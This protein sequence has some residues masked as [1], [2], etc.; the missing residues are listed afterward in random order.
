MPHLQRAI[1]HARLHAGG[2]F[3]QSQQIC[4]V[5]ARFVDD[6]GQHF[7]GM[8]EFP[9]K[10]LICLRFLDRVKVLALDILDQRDLE[11]SRIVEVANDDRDLVQPRALR[12]PPAALSRHDLIIMTMR[13]HDDRLDQPARRDRCREFVEQ[14]IVEMTPRLIGMRR[15]RAY[16]QHA[17]P[18]GRRRARGYRC[19]ACNFP[20]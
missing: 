12:R 20:E 19:F 9:R 2:Q 6:P 18:G 15:H 17:H 5:T 11:R 10:L 3:E 4:D 13:P 14:M 16:R 8:P 7:L 1:G